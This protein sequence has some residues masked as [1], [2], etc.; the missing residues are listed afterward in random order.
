MSEAID[1]AFEADNSVP[2]GGVTPLDSILDVGAADVPASTQD[3]EPSL[4]GDAPIP[5]EPRV[6]LSALKKERERRRKMDS[7]V[8]ELEEELQRFNDQRWGFDEDTYN[9]SAPEQQGESYSAGQDGSQGRYPGDAIEQN[10]NKSL[11]SFT[12][13]YG[14]GEV[15]AVDAALKQLTPAQ[16]QE[17]WGIV[18]KDRDPAASV[19]AYVKRLGLLKHERPSLEDVLAGKAPEADTSNTDQRFADLSHREQAIH[20][21]ER[22][23]IKAASRSEFVSEYGSD[24]YAQLDAVVGQL[25]QNPAAQQHVQQLDAAIYASSHPIYTAAQLLSEWGVWEPAQVQRQPAAVYPSNFAGSRSVAPR[26]GP[27]WGGPTPLGDIFDRKS[28]RG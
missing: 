2:A 18:G 19:H 27:A 4:D 15:A 12:D 7:R 20:T 13:K 10:Y 21:A 28:G 5:R 1:Q 24:A 9:E 26:R 14:Q 22:R 8:R 6:A 3:H 16:Q 11:Q 25:L 17:V 23:A